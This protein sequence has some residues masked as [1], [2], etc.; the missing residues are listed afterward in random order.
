MPSYHLGYVI[1]PQLANPDNRGPERWELTQEVSNA[2]LWAADDGLLALHHN[3]SLQQRFALHE[4]V[5]D[6][7][8]VIDVVVRVELELLELRVLANKILD[9][10]FET[11]DDLFERSTVRRLFHVQND[12]VVN[13]QILGDRQGIFG[14]TSMRV[15]IDRYFRHGI[16]SSAV[17]AT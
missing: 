17:D 15:V 9:R 12:I 10:V 16:S 14:R 13:T 8:W 7:F 11:S 3:G 2:R 1:A 4:Q 5:D 6:R